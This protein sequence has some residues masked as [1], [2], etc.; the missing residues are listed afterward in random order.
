M[1]DNENVSVE[2]VEQ[3]PA[4]LE[5][6]Q[7]D[8]Y[9]GLYRDLVSREVAFREGR[10]EGQSV[11]VEMPTGDGEPDLISYGQS[12][13]VER[14]DKL[15]DK[16]KVHH[17]GVDV[18]RFPAGD[19]ELVEKVKGMAIRQTSAA[20]S[21]RH[22]LERWLGLPALPEVLEGALSE[23]EAKAPGSEVETEGEVEN[24]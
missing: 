14:F 7:D 22:E 20:T 10:P 15:L 18:G 8:V 4:V 11:V 24:E 6:C 23:L 12:E 1:E 19:P 21:R 5:S 17:R 3:Q 9:D 2:P 16:D 13:M